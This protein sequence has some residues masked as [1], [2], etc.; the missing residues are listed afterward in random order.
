MKKEELN[1]IILRI[2]KEMPNFQHIINGLSYNS[3][4]HKK[5]VEVYSFELLEAEISKLITIKKFNKYIEQILKCIKSK[6]AL[7]LTNQ[8]NILK[9]KLV[10]HLKKMK[11]DTE[12][13][14]EI[15]SLNPNFYGIG[16]NLKALWNKI[17][18]IKV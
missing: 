15:I 17:T 10:D 7:N 6:D 9:P 5:A 4:L 13:T 1:N 18:N 2:D 14:N 3:N 16:I 12:I 8:L 11:S